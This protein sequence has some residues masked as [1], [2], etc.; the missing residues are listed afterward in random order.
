MYRKKATD[1][2]YKEGDEFALVQVDDKHDTWDQ[3]DTPNAA[4]KGEEFEP[5][6]PAK[7][8]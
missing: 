1:R 8:K 7:K 4:L 6:E 2:V 3:T 5:V